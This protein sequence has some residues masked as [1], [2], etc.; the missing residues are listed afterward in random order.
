MGRNFIV[1][2][3]C[4]NI[5][6]GEDAMEQKK[7]SLFWGLDQSFVNKVMYSARKEHLKGDRIIFEQ[8]DPADRVYFLLKGSVELT[9][10][11]N[12]RLVYTITRN[13]E[14]FGWSSLIGGDV[15]SATART[16]GPTRLLSIARDDLFAIIEKD[17][18]SGVI[19]FE[20]VAA[21]LGVR[22]MKMY[23]NVSTTYKP[24]PLDFDKD[25]QMEIKLS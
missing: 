16:L 5:E 13:G 21:I 4:T 8:G 11:K 23:E 17:P 24:F 10:G 22:L 1:F 18:A 15:Y 9:I 6:K 2:G 14:F 12:G 3:F 25:Q 7:T 20:R 19:V